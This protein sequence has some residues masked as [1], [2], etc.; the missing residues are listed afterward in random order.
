MTP[1]DLIRET[2]AEAL[3]Q[4]SA[5]TFN[6]TREQLDLAAKDAVNRNL[7]GLVEAFRENANAV[8]R[9]NEEIRQELASMR[10]DIS[11]VID[12]HD[13]CPR[14]RSLEANGTCHLP[15]DG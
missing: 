14:C 5:G 4:I 2:V 1:A 11:R 7:L 9:S 13:R 6:P 10:D 8:I 3:R 15:V 12:E